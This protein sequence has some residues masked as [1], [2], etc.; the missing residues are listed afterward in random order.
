MQGP[1][2]LYPGLIPEYRKCGIARREIEQGEDD[3][4]DQKED[5]DNQ[6]KAARNEFHDIRPGRGG[7]PPLPGT[8]YGFNQTWRNRIIP[9]AI[10]TKPCTFRLIVLY[11][12]GQ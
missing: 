11:S 5:S 2:L 12:L 10:K 3:H 9:S 6:H 8:V 4:A 1:E 7:R